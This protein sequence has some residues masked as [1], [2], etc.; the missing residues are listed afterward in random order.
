[1][2]SATRSSPPGARSCWP[3][4]ASGFSGYAASDRI[5]EQIA[6]MVYVDS[7]PGKGPLNPEFE[8]AD[9]PLNWD[10]VSEEENLDGLSEEQM[11]AFRRRAVRCRAA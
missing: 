8:G 9:N 11:E 4:T 7:A 1:M 10:E 5:P 6:A 3:C 2:R